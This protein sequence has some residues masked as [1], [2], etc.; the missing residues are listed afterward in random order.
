[1]SGS[2]LGDE[3]GILRRPPCRAFSSKPGGSSRNEAQTRCRDEA[4]VVILDDAPLPA[5][6]F[7]GDA[8]L[9]DLFCGAAARRPDAIAL[10]DPPNRASF[11]DGPARRLTYAQADRAI[12]ALA[13]LLRRLNLPTD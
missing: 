6:G 5:T 4:L 12:A 3:S 1:M 9:D 13:G 8:S 7:A 11:T 10:C 2:H